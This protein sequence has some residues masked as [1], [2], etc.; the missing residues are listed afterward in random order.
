MKKYLRN[1][2]LFFVLILLYF[3]FQTNAASYAAKVQKPNIIV[4]LVDDMGLMDT[5]VPFMVDK[6]GKPKKYPLN[7]WYRTPGMERLAALGI[8]FTDFYAHNVCSPSRSSILNGQNSARHRTTNWIAQDHKNTGENGPPEWNYDGLT[9]KDV[10]LPVILRNEG[11]NTIII[12]KAHLGAPNTEGAE[13]LNLGFDVNIAGC[14]IGHPGSYYG[15][16]SYGRGKDNKIYRV[17]NLEKYHGTKTFLTEALTLEAKSEIDKSIQNQKPFYLYMS[18]YAVHAPFESDPRFIKNYDESKGKRAAAFATLIEGMDKSLGDLIDHLEARGIAE[19]TLILFLGDNGSDAPIVSK[20][21]IN[22]SAPLRGKKGNKWEG[23][24]RVPFIAAW[25]SPN[26]KNKWQKKLPIQSGGVQ[27]QIGAC[28]DL[29]PTITK[30]INIQVPKD[31][32]VDGQC[33][34]ILLKGEK[35]PKRTNVFLSH[36]PHPR[37]DK[38]HFTTYRSGDWKLIYHYFPKLS[39]IKKGNCLLYNLKTDIS[40]SND[41]SQK[42]PEK[43]KELIAA[44]VEDLESKNALY[45]VDKSGNIIKP[46]LP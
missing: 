7:N 27:E 21:D 38:K 35:D 25:A 18:H 42:H 2:R 44:M 23:G 17:P 43:V 20:S 45:P 15:S 22:S 37:K 41:L 31:H 8:R 4:F 33:L 36:F 19:N 46:K 6:N 5:S 11:Y 30:L 1:R 10:T 39:G 26:S 40:E 29:F 16:Q 12:G 28:F 34:N 14:S 13:P 32:V 24:V 3:I 9:S